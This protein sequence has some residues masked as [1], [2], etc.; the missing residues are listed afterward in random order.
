[1]QTLYHYKCCIVISTSFSGSLRF[2]SF[3]DARGR[4]SAGVLRDMKLA[5]ESSLVINGYKGPSPAVG[6]PDFDLVWGFTVEYMH[7][8]L[9]GVI[10]QITEILLS[11]VNSNERFYIGKMAGIL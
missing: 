7:A 3:E 8:V 6:L 5:L 4:T 10:R 11:S 2:L 9:L 1:M